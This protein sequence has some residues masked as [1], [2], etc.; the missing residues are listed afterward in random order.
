VDEDQGRSQWEQ[1]TLSCSH[2]TLDCLGAS[3]RLELAW[4]NDLFDATQIVEELRK[5]VVELAFHLWLQ[6]SAI[7]LGDLLRSQIDSHVSFALNFKV[8]GDV[9]VQSHTLA[10]R[11]G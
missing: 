1:V 5:N 2:R 10:Q 7:L 6:L 11:L 8:H 9:V 3:V 4:H